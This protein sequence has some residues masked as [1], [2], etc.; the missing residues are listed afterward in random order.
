[1]LRPEFITGVQS[2][3][4]HNLAYD[5]LVFEDQLREALAFVDSFKEGTFVVDHIAKPRIRENSI[6]AWAQG[7]RELATRENVY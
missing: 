4:D 7:I 1:M 6:D 3:L 2:V 5:I